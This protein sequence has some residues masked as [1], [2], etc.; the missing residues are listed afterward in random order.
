MESTST[1]SV[2]EL[3]NVPGQAF[4]NRTQRLLASYMVEYLPTVIKA[5][6]SNLSAT[7]TKKKRNTVYWVTQAYEPGRLV[8]KLRQDY[9][10]Y[11]VQGWP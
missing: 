10:R 5:L 4:K 1:S 8:G 6:N 2:L 11:R 7:P 3:K 9:L